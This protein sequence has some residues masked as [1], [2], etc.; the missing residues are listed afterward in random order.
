MTHAGATLAVGT[1]VDVPSWVAIFGGL[2]AF[3][4]LIAGGIAVYRQTSIREAL[5]ALQV[6][7][8]ELREANADLRLELNAERE[9]RAN[10]EGRLDAITTH[11]AHQLV[12]AVIRTVRETANQPT[13][14]GSNQ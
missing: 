9:K 12:D 7:N 6:N 10:L 1:T 14:Q 3:V 5:A 13:T 4:A 11:L 2:L 8:T